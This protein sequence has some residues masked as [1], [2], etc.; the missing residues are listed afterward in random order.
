MT[1]SNRRPIACKA[2]A[3]PTEL[4]PQKDNGADGEIRTPDPRITNALPYH[5]ATSASFYLLGFYLTSDLIT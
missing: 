4:I 2:I 3:L 1:G 5:W